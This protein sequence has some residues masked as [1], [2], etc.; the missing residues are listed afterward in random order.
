VW[1]TRSDLRDIALPGRQDELVAAVAAA[2]PRTV[3]VLQ[4]GGPVEM[5]WLDAVSA[6][7]QAWYPGQE[8]GNGRYLP[9]VPVRP[10]P[11]LHAFRDRGARGRARGRRRRRSRDRSQCR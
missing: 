11:R 9:A 4:T 2:N 1:L 3:V 8:A 5:P 7:L 10:R 6:V